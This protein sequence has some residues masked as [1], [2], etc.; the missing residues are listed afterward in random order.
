MD[1]LVENSPPGAKKLIFTPWLHGERSPIN[2]P[3]L[4]GQLF[5]IGMYHDRSDIIRAVFESV[6]YNLR[7][8]IDVVENLSKVESKTITVIGGGS[9]SDVWCQIFADVWQKDVVRLKQPQMASGLGA[10]CIALVSLGILSDFTGVSKLIDVDQIFKPDETKIPLYSNL[11][12]SFK[13]L[14]KR[15]KK[16]FHELNE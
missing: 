16:V 10:A 7:W 12:E 6:A 13:K 2:D 11:F 15:N 8:G 14:Y 3:F 5:N 9:K 4:R 1:I